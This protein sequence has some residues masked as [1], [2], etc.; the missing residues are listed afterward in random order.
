MNEP[1]Q[2][3]VV[4]Q[5]NWGGILLISRVPRGLAL[6][7]QPSRVVMGFVIVVMLM[8]SGSIWDGIF[9]QPVGFGGLGFVPQ[10]GEQLRQILAPML[11]DARLVRS[12][13]AEELGGSG[14][15]SVAAVRSAVLETYRAKS[16]EEMERDDEA[17]ASAMSMLRAIAP[18]GV[19]EATA[20]AVVD[21]FHGML[22]AAIHLD[23]AGVGNQ[24]GGFAR[25][26]SVLFRDH[27]LFTLV[28]GAWTLVVGMIGVGAICRTAA[29]QFAVEQYIT[30]T[31]ALAFALKRW[32][33]ILGTM[34]LPMV[35]LSLG[36]LALAVGGILL[37]VPGLNVIGSVFYGLALFGGTIAACL[38]LLT[39]LASGLFIPAVAVESADAPDALARSF[40]FVRNRPLHW[41]VYV[42]AALIQGLFGLLIV[43]LVASLTINF[44]AWGAGL[45]ISP[46]AIEA[47]GGGAGLTS[48][49][50]V[51]SGWDL[52][53]T[54]RMAG[55]LIVLWRTV[56]GGLV[57]G[58]VVSYF[59]CAT[60]VLYFLMRK[61]TDGQ[62]LEEIWQP[63]LIE[64][65]MAPGRA[66][67]VDAGEAS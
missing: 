42:I 9:G 27:L 46:P 62:D 41:V 14:A 26:G 38:I 47:V 39:L 54:H 51:D 22:G 45:F 21:R 60:T 12:D 56:A 66:S 59:A 29:C 43:T 18:R 63:G 65:T 20:A 34:A 24:L 64:G 55:G 57:A 32:I 37:A 67:V 19:F 44:V 8:A 7:L 1:N 13:L 23:P 35:A 5:V 3:V 10:T 52:L 16:A 11:S 2:S 36:A 49:L 17:V 33:P 25:L 61:A 40:S 53:G 4:D 28:F 50:P 30:W 48:I 58:W 6:S 15:Q 31:T